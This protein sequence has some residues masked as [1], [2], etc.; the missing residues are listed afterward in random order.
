MPAGVIEN[1]QIV[2]NIHIIH[3]HTYETVGI[4]VGMNNIIEKLWNIVKY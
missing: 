2:C 3:T 4:R 1:V